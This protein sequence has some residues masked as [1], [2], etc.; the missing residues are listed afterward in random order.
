MIDEPPPHPDL[1]WLRAL[2][3][4]QF[5]GLRQLVD[6]RDRRYGAESEASKQAVKDALAA[7]EKAVNAALQ[8]SDKA[9]AAAEINAEKWRLNANEWR[10]AM[11]DR[12]RNLMPIVQAEQRFTSLEEK[13]A[14]VT[15]WQQAA[16]GSGSGHRESVAWLFGGCGVIIGFGTIVIEIVRIALVH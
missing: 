2:I 13:I 12:E 1:L 3:D 8:A 16:Q 7:Q 4:A 6:E 11:N 14:S 5:A 10:G 9:V 15:A